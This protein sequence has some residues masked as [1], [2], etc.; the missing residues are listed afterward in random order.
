MAASK[1]LFRAQLQAAIVQVECWPTADITAGW[2]VVV[3][4]QRRLWCI[5][6]LQ[7]LL[8]G[9]V[10]QVLCKTPFLR[11]YL[12]AQSLVPGKMLAQVQHSA[13]PV[14]AGTAAS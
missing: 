4:L 7:M 1:A 10:P 13:T 11:A 2:G 5:R 12:A 8:A 3:V 14:A 6:L 9:G